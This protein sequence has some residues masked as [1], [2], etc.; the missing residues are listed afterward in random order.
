MKNY[1]ENQSNNLL[2]NQLLYQ[3]LNQNIQLMLLYYE[4]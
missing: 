1:M 4:F 2:L 3:D